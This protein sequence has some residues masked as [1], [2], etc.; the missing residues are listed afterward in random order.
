MRKKELEAFTREA[1]KSIK[2]EKALN[3]FRR[4]LTKVTVET[5]L[6]D[7]HSPQL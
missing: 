2:S 1:D 7:L 3:D 5:V 4:M 6:N